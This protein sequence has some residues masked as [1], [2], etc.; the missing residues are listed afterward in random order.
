MNVLAVLSLAIAPG[1]FWLWFFYKRDR[2]NP[3]PTHLIIRT[4]FFGILVAFPIVVA[5]VFFLFLPAF[6][7]YVVIAP[8]TEEYGKFAV[9]RYGIYNS[10]EFDEPIDGIV[11]GA[12]S[13]LGFATIENIGY[14]LGSYFSPE[15]VIGEGASAGDAV[16]FL[17]IAR[18]LLSVP[19]HAIWASFWGYGLGVARFA[20]PERGRRL[21]HNGLILAIVS[22]GL[23]NGLLLLHPLLAFGA[24]LVIGMGWRMTFQRISAARAAS[25]YRAQ[26]TGHQHRE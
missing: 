3:E 4:F 6:L 7:L 18:S 15:E 22:H 8:I 5:Q 14:L 10:T 12:A 25:A 19:G 20:S 13:A 26:S 1:I 9:V 23:F 17:F 16:L 21:I 11:Y 24:L 2:P